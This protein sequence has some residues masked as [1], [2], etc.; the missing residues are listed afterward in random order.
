MLPELF[1]FSIMTTKKTKSTRRNDNKGFKQS[2][3][4]SSLASMFQRDSL[5][6]VV[7]LFS[8][9]IPLS[10]ILAVSSPFMTRSEAPSAVHNGTDFEEV[11][12]YG[13]RLGAYAAYYFMDNCFGASA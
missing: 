4:N 5:R 8:I 11:Q 6:F 3:I 9:I 2:I 7:G 10:W 13:G 1:H 12:N